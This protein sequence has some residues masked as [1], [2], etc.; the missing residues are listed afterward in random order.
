MPCC[1][2][3]QVIK[4]SLESLN[5]LSNTAYSTLIRSSRKVWPLKWEEEGL[6]VDIQS[7]YVVQAIAYGSQGGWIL[8]QSRQVRSADYVS[9]SL[10]FQVS[11]GW[12]IGLLLQHPIP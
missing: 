4:S 5:S 1:Q 8:A 2:T 7:D 11:R 10:T 6:D 12:A 3:R 9:H